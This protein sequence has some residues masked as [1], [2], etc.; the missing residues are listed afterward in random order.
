MKMLLLSAGN[1]LCSVGQTYTICILQI[2][3]EISLARPGDTVILHLTV[4]RY[5]NTT[6]HTTTTY[7]ASAS[8][9]RCPVEVL[10]SYRSYSWLQ[11]GCDSSNTRQ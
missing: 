4:V 3:H 9:D 10:S 11:L 7:L 1:L 5:H 2:Y 8:V 6:R